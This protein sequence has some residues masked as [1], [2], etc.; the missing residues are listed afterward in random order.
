VSHA[1]GNPTTGIIGAYQLSGGNGTWI[2]KWDGLEFPSECISGREICRRH[3]LGG[4]YVFGTPT[5]VLYRAD[6][7]RRAPSFFPGAPTSLHGDTSA[8]YE[9][10]RAAD[11]GFVHEVLSFE[12]IHE[13]AASTGRRSMQSYYFGA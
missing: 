10:L 8:C 6:L 7:V 9:H 1:V 11:F 13:S 12:R 4:P 5:S 3:L 2:V